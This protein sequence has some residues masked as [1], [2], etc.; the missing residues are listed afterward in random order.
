MFPLLCKLYGIL[1]SLAW[2]FLTDVS[3]E[4]IVPIFKAYAGEEFFFYCMNLE[5]E[6]DR[7]S[8]NVGKK[9]TPFYVV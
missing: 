8:R 2:E 6:T 5:D 7:F 1:W 9:K 4:P 3:E